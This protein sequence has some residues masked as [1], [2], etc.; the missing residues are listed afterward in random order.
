M[1]FQSRIT[2]PIKKSDLVSF[3]PSKAS[4]SLLSLQIYIQGIT[5]PAIIIFLH[6]G[7]HQACY[8]NKYTSRAS[9]SL[10]SLHFYIQGITKSAIYYIFTFYIQGITESTIYYIFTSRASLSLLYNVLQLILN[11]AKK[12]YKNQSW[13]SSQG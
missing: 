11:L 3:Q 2:R 5:K 13:L 12:K 9:P 6:P 4:S 7:H 10:L 1:A 8:H